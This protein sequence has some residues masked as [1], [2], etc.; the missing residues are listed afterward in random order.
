MKVLIQ[1]KNLF[2]E[3]KHPFQWNSILQK[4]EYQFSNI[5]IA[6][7]IGIGDIGNKSTLE[8]NILTFLSLCGGGTIENTILRFIELSNE[9]TIEEIELVKCLSEFVKHNK[10]ADDVTLA[11]MLMI[12]LQKSFHE[13]FHVRWFVAEALWNLSNS[14]LKGYI[15]AK[16]YE[17]SEDA[18]YTL[19]HRIIILAREMYQANP[20]IAGLIIKKG[21]TDNNYLVR[22]EANEASLQL[23]L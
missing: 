15:H 6:F 8:I 23:G 20:T 13:V 3:E 17:L 14:K 1:I 10:Y 9:G 11:S 5:L 16:L 22:K 2:E 19:R 12:L 21:I 18:N 4:I 7:E